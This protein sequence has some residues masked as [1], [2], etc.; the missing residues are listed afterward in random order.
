[1]SS[2]T[3]H[4]PT[5]APRNTG[6]DHAPTTPTEPVDHGSYTTTWSPDGGGTMHWAND[7][8]SPY[9]VVFAAGSVLPLFLIGSSLDMKA[10]TA[11]HAAAAAAGG[12]ILDNAALAGQ[13]IKVSNKYTYGMVAAGAALT[14]AGAFLSDRFRDRSTM[15]KQMSWQDY[16]R[17]GHHAP[18]DDGQSSAVRLVTTSG[19]SGVSGALAANEAW[20]LLS[21]TP[22]PVRLGGS[23][24]AG[25]GTI[26]LSSH[27]VGK[28]FD[29]SEE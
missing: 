11:A 26:L 21:S 15:D 14:I 18:S 7:R 20:K 3:S 10:A 17:A 4:A 19:I 6:P 12:G 27:L 28:A 8:P 13:T 2:I 16:R 1:M 25:I 29:Q 24:V 9:P 5:S 22:V 23:L